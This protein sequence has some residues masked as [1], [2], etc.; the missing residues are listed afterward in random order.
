MLKYLLATAAGL[1]LAASAGAVTF[2]TLPGAPDL[3]APGQVVV[4]DFD[5]P[6]AAGY[7]WSGGL[8]I[9]V[10][11]SSNAAAPAGTAIG[12]NYGYVSS[13]LNPNTATLTTPDLKSISFYWG[14]I[15]SYNKLEVLDDGGNVLL[16]LF[17]NTPGVGVPPIIGHQGN[18]AN[19]RRL[20]L[21]AEGG[22]TIGGLRFTSTGVAFE[23]DTIT[24]GAVPEPA[25]WA[26]LLAGFGMVG[27]ASRRRRTLERVTA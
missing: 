14:S 13:S 2:L 27:L 3:G 20:F 10:G 25:T 11:S 19:N 5:S 4:V 18:Q 9:G 16:T 12:T 8:A 15:D 17:G 21:H 7:S 6:I 23:F 24:A 1:G 26:M 22:E